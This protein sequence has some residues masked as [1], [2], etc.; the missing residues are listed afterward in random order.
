[1]LDFFVPVKRVRVIVWLWTDLNESAWMMH[2]FWLGKIGNGRLEQHLEP[3][4][5]KN[6]GMHPSVLRAMPASNKSSWQAASSGMMAATIGESVA[7][8]LL[9]SWSKY[10]EFLCVQLCPGWLSLGK[11]QDTARYIMLTC[12][13][14]QDCPPDLASALE[15]WGMMQRLKTEEGLGT[16]KMTAWWHR[17]AHCPHISIWIYMDIIW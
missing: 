3:W 7:V 11:T 6:Q 14:E 5:G 4:E 1:M 15:S 17:I 16:Q 10:I 13:Q 12:H 2:F 8:D 9:T